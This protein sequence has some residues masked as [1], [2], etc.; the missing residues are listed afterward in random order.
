MNTPNFPDANISTKMKPI[1]YSREQIADL[2]GC[3]TRTV[4]RYEKLGMPVLIV[5]RTHKYIYQEVLHWFATFKST[6]GGEKHGQR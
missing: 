2:I 4:Q 1:L 6:K 5:N 3:S